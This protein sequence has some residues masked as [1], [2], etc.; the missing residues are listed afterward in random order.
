VV[1]LN[2]VDNTDIILQHSMFAAAT[3]KVLD[4]CDKNDAIGLTASKF[5]NREFVD[6]SVLSFNWAGYSREH[7]YAV[8]KVL[9]ENDFPPL[10]FIHE[11]LTGLKWGRHR[12]NEFKLT[13]N[14]QAV[15]GN[16][17]EIFNQTA[18]FYLFRFDHGAFSRFDERP[19]GNW[20][21]FLNV[22]DKEIKMG[23]TSNAL[24]DI[25]YGSDMTEN[26]NRISKRES[27]L[28]NSVLRPLCW[29]GLLK[30]IRPV[31]SFL[32]DAVFVKSPLWQLV[33]S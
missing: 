9:N 21:I 29:I 17:P 32:S 33:I 31:N 8:N 10:G 13:K 20:D 18:P 19:L 25:L 24:C 30:E 27:I 26:R 1:K 12:K 15:I 4:Y 16:I 2:L 14:G 3:A 28:Y 11:T 23:I 5:F 7:L 6:W 22:I